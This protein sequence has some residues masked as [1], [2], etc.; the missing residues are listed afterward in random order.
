MDRGRGALVRDLEPP[1]GPRARG[2]ALHESFG[3]ICAQMVEASLDGERLPALRPAPVIAL[4][5]TA[6]DHTRA[7]ILTRLQFAHEGGGEELQRLLADGLRALVAELLAL[8]GRPPECIVGVAAAGNPGICHL[9]CRLPVGSLLF[10][11][12][13]SSLSG[14]TTIPTAA[15]QRGIVHL[16]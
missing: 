12:H 4:T 16:D 5:A 14:L 1:H 13:R 11:P 15:I 2:V 7:D 9:L 3:S 6:D 10:P 8:A